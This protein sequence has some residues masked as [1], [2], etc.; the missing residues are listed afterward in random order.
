MK[1]HSSRIAITIGFAAMMV[2]LIVLTAMWLVTVRNN[3]Q[4]LQD[5]VEDHQARQDVFIMRDSVLKRAIY[6]H[7]M[8]LADDE[9][10]RDKL[11][12][13]F[14]LL[15]AEF[16]TARDHLLTT[17]MINK[18]RNVW[19][20][21]Q[22]KIGQNYLKQT[23]VAD[24]IVADRLQEA[25]LTMVND[26]IPLQNEI[27][28]SLTRMLEVGDD[29]VRVK[30]ANSEKSNHAAYV[31]IGILG[32]IIF[33]IGLAIAVLVLKRTQAYEQML[34]KARE[35]EANANQQKSLFLANMSHEIRTPL[36]AIIGFA[37]ILLDES[38]TQ[39]EHT[40]AARTIKENGKHLLHVINEILDVS[41]IESNK[42]SIEILKTDTNKIFADIDSLLGMQAKGKGLL[43]SIQYTTPVPVYI[44][45][46]PTRLKQ[47]LLNLCSNAIKF[48][49]KG[50]VQV[51]VGFDPGAET[52]CCEVVDTGV[53]ISQEQAAKLFSPF[54]QADSSTTRRF[55]GTG[56][57]LY[58]SKQLAEKLGGSL[59]IESAHGLGARVVMKIKTGVIDNSQM[60]TGHQSA[61]HKPDIFHSII[62]PKLQGNIL[63]A[64]DSAD[65][66]C[67]I[68]LY[69]NKTGANIDTADNG[70]IAFDMAL[71]RHYDLIL[72]DMQMP[73][74]DGV[75]TTAQLRK[76]N[77]QGKIVALTA[78]ATK[79][80][81]QRCL[82]AGCDSFLSKPI[83]RDVFYAE[84]AKYLQVISRRELAN[85]QAYRGMTTADPASDSSLQFDTKLD[86]E[87]ELLDLAANFI[88]TLPGRIQEI[89]AALA[90]QRWQDLTS[91]F[92][93]LKG[94]GTSFGFPE[95][96][97]MAGDIELQIKQEQYSTLPIFL[98]QFITLLESSI[99]RFELFKKSQSA[100]PS[101]AQ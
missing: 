35:A 18:Q 19:N 55:G 72:M 46:D 67:L 7:R 84:L 34:L 62:I 14:M 21:I 81:R 65:N 80:D 90:T 78:N 66:Q 5:L 32:S 54:T 15:A 70:K 16:V 53:G 11:H 74:M 42:L 92:H 39:K 93:Q 68:K 52:L 20:D 69:I 83:D 47:I 9:F 25:K 100:D 37:G 36:T 79:E 57:G 85:E 3:N 23:R 44:Q 43:F 101:A 75:T 95:I 33:G 64:E 51:L 26:V 59:S 61:T 30:I 27:L 76:M 10:E 88:A 45:T 6:L 87:V 58:I 63:L 86:I 31:L 41:K 96:T 40:N 97:R 99:R 94:L 71:S 8:M 73:V 77:Y 1:I 4:Q 50:S 24:L 82:Q 98:P 49:E 13:D 91:L 28:I 17:Q 48:T 2:L 12:I 38:V 56:L 60:S 22:Y 29:D 89:Q